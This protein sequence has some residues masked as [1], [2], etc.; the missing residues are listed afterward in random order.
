M[1]DLRQSK[2]LDLL[3]FSAGDNIAAERRMSEL[4]AESDDE[5]NDASV[6]SGQS[7]LSGKSGR[8]GRRQSVRSAPGSNAGR[9]LGKC[10]AV[11][12]PVK[13]EA[14]VAVVLPLE[15]LPPPSGLLLL[16]V[17]W[18]NLGETVWGR[19]QRSSGNKGR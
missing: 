19:T 7:G 14:A 17:A 2:I 16:Q 10:V 4:L 6:R 13:L 18:R 9:G 15:V 12:A 11:S 5:G 8:S 1:Q 3:S